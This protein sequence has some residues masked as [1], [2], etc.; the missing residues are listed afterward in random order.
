M[1]MEYIVPILRV[2][3]VTEM[4]DVDVVEDI[5]LQPVNL[6]EQCFDVG[7]HQNVEKKRKKVSHDRHIKS[8]HF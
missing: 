5:L 1:P 4:I 2:G 8:K 7:F 3:A 6:E